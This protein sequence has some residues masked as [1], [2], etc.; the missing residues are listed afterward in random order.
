MKPFRGGHLDGIYLLRAPSRLQ[1]DEAG[2]L[3][4]HLRVKVQVTSN[5]LFW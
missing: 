3:A 4:M 2:D 1:H 5:P